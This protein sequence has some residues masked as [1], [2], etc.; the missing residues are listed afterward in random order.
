MCSQPAAPVRPAPRRM[1]GPL[2]LALAR[3]AHA[4]RIVACSPDAPRDRHGLSYPGI[5]DSF[6]LPDGRV[7]AVPPEKVEAW[8]RENHARLLDELGI[9]VL[10]TDESLVRDTESARREAYPGI[11]DS[12]FLPDGRVGAV[13]PEKVAA[14]RRENLPPWMADG[15]PLQQE[16]TPIAPPSPEADAEAR[17]VA[18]VAAGLTKADARRVLRREPL[19][20][21]MAPATLVARLDALGAALPRSVVVKVARSEPPP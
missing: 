6:F 8:R 21:K 16:L 1:T 4:I 10:E 7:G 3:R 14:W 17:M 12:F 13:P 18:L 11:P 9:D 15:Y 5:P 20:A 2:L 19:L